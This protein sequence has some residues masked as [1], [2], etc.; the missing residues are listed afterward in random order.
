MRHESASFVFAST[1]RLPDARP[2]CKFHQAE[3][4]GRSDGR[5]DTSCSNESKFVEE[6][7]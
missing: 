7:N 6:T 5:T 3:H 4:D 2:A 1:I